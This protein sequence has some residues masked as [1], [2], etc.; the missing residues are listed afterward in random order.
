MSSFDDLKIA[1]D[2]AMERGE[3]L[4][5]AC[6]C[7]VLYSG[8]A[9]SF[10]PDGDRIIIIKSDKTLIV[11]Q[12]SG[13]TAVNYMKPGGTHDLIRSEH[14]VILKSR[15]EGEFLDVT[16]S[17]IH[18][19]NSH[20]LEDGASLQLSGTE[21]DMS[22]MIFAN[23]KLIS[24]YFKPLSREEHTKVGFIDVMGYEGGVL[25]V[26]ECKRNAADPKA[27]D[28]L[29]RYVEDIKKVKGVE[30]VQGVL[31][32]PSMSP[33]A[34]RMLADLGFGF[35]SLRP[36]KYMEKKEKAQMRLDGF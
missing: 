10:L 21:K 27:V 31:A 36:P 23:P 28:Q 13:H 8:R 26:V 15:N 34:E 22:D 11:H 2:Y 33:K 9:E 29:R 18:F 16:I 20:P 19:F 1:F 32:C 4:V 14:K 12:P 6:R 30:K 17:R 5:V 24:P 7:Q 3:S 35:V 25:T